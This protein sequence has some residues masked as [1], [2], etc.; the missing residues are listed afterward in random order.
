MLALS[1]LVVDVPDAYL[2]QAAMP[3]GINSLVIAHAYGLDLKIT[4]S[5]LAWTTAVVIA[6][7]LGA[8]A[9]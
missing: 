7:A 2:V 4:A 9:L 6:G 8:A 3:S 1:A 5:A